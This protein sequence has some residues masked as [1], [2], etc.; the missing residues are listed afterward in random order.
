M[1]LE[2]VNTV[3]NI[4]EILILGDKVFLREFDDHKNLLV[5]SLVQTDCSESA[6]HME[7]NKKAFEAEYNFPSGFITH[8]ESSS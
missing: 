5:F 7:I 6:I 4:A 8:V 1:A 3:R 2:K